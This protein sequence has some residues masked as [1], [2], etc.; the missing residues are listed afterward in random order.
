M[1]IVWAIAGLASIVGFLVM[2][3]GLAA[4]EG[5]PQQAAAAAIGLGIVIPFYTL[6]RD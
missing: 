1:K 5:A 4:A 6:A 3:T 2:V